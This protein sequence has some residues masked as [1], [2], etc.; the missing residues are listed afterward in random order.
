MAD[1]ND[2]S[3]PQWRASTWLVAGG[4]PRGGGA[5][6]NAPP[7]LAS[8]FQ[9][10]GRHYYSRSDG[11][12]TSDAFEELIGRLEGGSAISFASGLGACSAVFDQM[13]AGAHVA[14]PVDCYQGVA[15]LVADGETRGRWTARRLEAGDTDAWCT[16]VR[17]CD[18]VWLAPAHQRQCKRSLRCKRPTK[19]SCRRWASLR[20]GA[21]LAVDVY[22]GRLVEHV[23][24]IRSGCFEV[25]AHLGHVDHV[26]G[27][28]VERQ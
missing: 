1:A 8:N 5:P 4:R 2:P 21:R 10:G 18:L 24:I 22:Q 3:S 15:Q 12:E 27:D 14:V 9:D 11:T 16:A 6:L 28:V 26:A 19:R 23:A 25:F 20:F 7:V 13:P 17:D